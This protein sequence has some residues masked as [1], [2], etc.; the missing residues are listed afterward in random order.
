MAYRLMYRFWLDVTKPNEESIADQIELLKNER[1]FTATIRDGIRLICDLK[2]G[3][4]DVLCELFP[5]FKTMLT[6]AP[7]TDGEGG[8]KD[9]IARLERLILEQNSQVNSTG[10]A[11]VAAAPKPTLKPIGQGGIR[12]LTTMPVTAPNFNDDDDSDLLVVKKDETAGK[13]ATQ[14]FINAMMALQQ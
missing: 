2:D 10:H 7:V 8:L 14:N 1:S 12:Q 5:Q 6:L 11:P 9:D 4:T 3:K 13:R